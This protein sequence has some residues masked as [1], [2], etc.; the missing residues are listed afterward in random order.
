MASATRSLLRHHR[1]QVH[2]WQRERTSGPPPGCG[3]KTCTPSLWFATLRDRVSPVDLDRAESGLAVERS[4]AFPTERERRGPFARFLLQRADR[5]TVLSLAK[6]L[7][8]RR[9]PQ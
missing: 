8:T 9:N 3:V 4:R 1:P 6:L 5:Q 7:Q 2:R